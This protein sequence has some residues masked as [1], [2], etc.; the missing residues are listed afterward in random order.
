[1]KKT[2]ITLSLF[3]IAL[4]IS[5]QNSIFQY[6]VKDASGQMTSL[7]PYEGQ[8]ILI[9]NT[10]TQ[11]GF[12]PQ[13][14]E[15]EALYQKYKSKG[16]IILDF[17]CNQFGG[18]AP[19]S[20]EDIHKYCTAKYDIHFPQFSKIDVNG[21]NADPLFVYLKTERGFQGFGNDAKGKFMDRMLRK[22]D[23]NYDKT[24]D[25]K[26]NFTKFLIDKRGRVVARFEPTQPIADVEKAIVELLK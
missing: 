18:Q 16:F 25:I 6:K 8:V 21:V 3:F 22:K 13:Y 26:W 10:A 12:T 4:N 14:S 1:M 19:G 20:Y 17:P 9:V 7:S 24:P 15:L 23:P 5:A 11:C 2:L